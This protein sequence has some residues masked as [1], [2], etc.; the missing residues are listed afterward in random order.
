MR[1]V[2]AP[3]CKSLGVA[4]YALAGLVAACGRGATG[5]LRRLLAP[6]E[7]HLRRTA[8]SPAHAA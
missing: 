2:G 3:L 7:P 1:S 5:T 4:C 8:A 6:A